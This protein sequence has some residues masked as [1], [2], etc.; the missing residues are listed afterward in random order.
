MPTKK[1]SSPSQPLSMIE[2][3]ESR[4]LFIRGQKVMLDADLAELYGVTTKRLNE[5]AKRNQ[6]RFP[7]DFMVHLTREEAEGLN[8][9]QIA[10][11]SQKHRNSRFTPYAFTEHG[12]VMLASVLNSPIAIEASIRVVRA[13]VRLRS[14]LAAH[15][16]LAKQ[17]DALEKRTDT[18]FRAVFELIEKYIKPA[19]KPAKRIGFH[20]N[21][22]GR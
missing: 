9:S 20:T 15:K 17:I 3:V 22:K 21:S 7:E 1:A 4:I 18:N 12:A 6:A 13:F 16:Q 11:G 14:I 2:Q 5:Q 8:R 10:T 19:A